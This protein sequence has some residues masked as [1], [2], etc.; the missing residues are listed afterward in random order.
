[1]GQKVNF[2]DPCQFAKEHVDKLNCLFC[3][4]S[5]PTRG[6]NDIMD[7]NEYLSVC[8]GINIC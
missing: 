3:L 6:V 2:A 4:V 8:H 1:M 5:V 7:C